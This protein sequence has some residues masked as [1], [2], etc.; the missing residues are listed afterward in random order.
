MSIIPNY[1]YSFNVVVFILFSSHN[2]L[3]SLPKA[4]VSVTGLKVILLSGNI[5][6]QLPENFGSLIN[7]EELVSLINLDKSES[8]S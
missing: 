1:R 3:S 2:K 6:E 5:I 7:L 8:S 4:L